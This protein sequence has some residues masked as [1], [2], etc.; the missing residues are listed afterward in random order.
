LKIELTEPGNVEMKVYKDF[1]KAGGGFPSLLLFVGSVVL[2]YALGVAH[3]IA[4]KDWSLTSISGIFND[5]AST[6]N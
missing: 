3:D 4:L 2:A 5:F 1:F 6:C